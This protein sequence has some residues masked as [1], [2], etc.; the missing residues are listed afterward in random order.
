M[1]TVQLFFCARIVA[2]VLPADMDLGITWAEV[3][4]LKTQNKATAQ[5]KNEQTR[6]R[7]RMANSTLETLLRNSAPEDSTYRTRIA[8]AN[9]GSAASA[10]GPQQSFGPVLT[11]FRF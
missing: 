6:T 2:S 11:T 3:L 5:T 9:Y 10:I 7:A 1:P 4:A 8:S